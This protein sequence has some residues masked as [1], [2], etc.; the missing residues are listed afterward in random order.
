MKIGKK[1]RSFQVIKRPLRKHYKSEQEYIIAKA[2]Y[3][4]NKTPM[5][6]FSVEWEGIQYKEDRLYNTE[7][8]I[9]TKI[10]I[11]RWDLNGTDNKVKVISIKEGTSRII[12]KCDKG[13][14]VFSKWNCESDDIYF[15]WTCKGKKWHKKYNNRIYGPS[16]YYLS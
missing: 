6:G 5:G 10:N 11:K 16:Y 8:K 12:V 15:K 9:G 4:F 14:F 1:Y 2:G 7:I 13:I 3:K